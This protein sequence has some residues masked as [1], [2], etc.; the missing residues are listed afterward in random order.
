[1]MLRRFRSNAVVSRPVLSKPALSMAVLSMFCVLAGSVSPAFA[2]PAQQGQRPAQ[3]PDEKACQPDVIKM[4]RP[5]INQGDM[6]IL[7]CLQKNRAKL[8]PQC[9]KVL[10]D[11][12]V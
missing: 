8:S 5:V 2:Q 11:H 12:G 6:V 4:C 1:M 7:D 3:T 10:E 9:R